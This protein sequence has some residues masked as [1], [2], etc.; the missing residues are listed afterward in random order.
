MLRNEQYVGVW[1]WNKEKWVQVPGTRR[2]KRVPRPESEHVR[3]VFPELRIIPPR[4][5]ESV[6]AR[7]KRLSFKRSRGGRTPGSTK[8]PPSILAGI[9]RCGICGGSIAVVHRHTSDGYNYSTLGCTTH[10]S[11][12]AAICPHSRTV[13]EKKVRAAVLEMLS[14][15]LTVPDLLERFVA[16]FERRLTELQKTERQ[17]D[18]TAA[19]LQEQEARLRN[20]YDGLAK[21]GWSQGLADLIRDEE[22]KVAALR[23]SAAERRKVLP[24]V[25]PHPKIIEGYLR[26]LL[27]LLDADPVQ[28]REILAR[29]I[30]PLVLTPTEDGGYKITGA[31]NV[32]ALIAA[33]DGARPSDNESRRDPLRDFSRT[34]GRPVGE[35]G[36]PAGSSPIQIERLKPPVAR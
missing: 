20:L 22:A 2:Y 16:T 35:G 3:K 18:T 14:G 23:A 34:V 7:V 26:N 19:R 1:V 29:Y 24:N 15:H 13:S 6:Q 32:A 28:G 10:K 21:M 4:L 27:T 31:F 30:Q 9:L 36:P 8:H 12:G 25:L 5:W 11:R 17:P 33:E